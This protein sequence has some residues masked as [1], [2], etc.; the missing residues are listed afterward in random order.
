[1]NWIHEMERAEEGWARWEAQ[2][3]GPISC[4]P[5]G[6]SWVP[7]SYGGQCRNCGDTVGA[8]EL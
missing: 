4:G 6:H 1:M 5:G 7:T 8:D 2:R 3:R